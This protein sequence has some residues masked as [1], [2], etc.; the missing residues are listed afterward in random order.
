MHILPSSN[1]NVCQNRVVDYTRPVQVTFPA[2]RDTAVRP[3]RYGPKLS[4]KQNVVQH[5][6]RTRR[7]SA[8]F[9]APYRECAG[10]Q[11]HGNCAPIQRRM[12][13]RLKPMA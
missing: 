9:I 4:A 6:D 5:S 1:V 11:G 13:S 10:D 12:H 2:L 8:S 3:P 7:I